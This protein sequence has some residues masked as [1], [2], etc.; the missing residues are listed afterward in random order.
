M[1]A[2][3][4]TV[5]ETINIRTPVIIGRSYTETK[6]RRYW[7]YATERKVESTVS[8]DRKMELDRQSPLALGAINVKFRNIQ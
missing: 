3:D 1:F 2:W 4:N 5:E 8:G 6:P 7:V